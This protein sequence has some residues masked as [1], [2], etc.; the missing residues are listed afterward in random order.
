[1]VW[2]LKE[3]KTFRKQYPLNEIMINNSKWKYIDIRNNKKEDTIIFLH[4]T[5][6]SAEIFWLQL[7]YF[8]KDYRVIS[9]TISPIDD[10]FQ[11]ATQLLVII[12]QLGV[13][14]PI[15]LG[16]SYGG[17]IS[18]ILW[19]CDPTLIKTLVLSN[20][21]YS[22][23]KYYDRYNYLMKIKRF[24]PTFVLKNMVRK[25]L[26][27]IIHNET[28][29]YLL[30]QLN[31]SLDKTVLLA[32]LSGIVRKYS[33]QVVQMRNMLILETEND[34]LIPKSVQDNLKLTYSYAKVFTF[35]ESANH[36]PYLTRSHEYNKVLENYLK[37]N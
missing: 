14:S 28:R 13:N 9:F 33:I 35:P 1:M 34:P 6:G 16:T 22:T 5:T 20:S 21:F 7:L 31:Q 24:I 18:Q 27:L 17:Y 32:R 19:S 4:G 26:Q 23:E 10:P 30:T 11:V 3:L 37:G 36:F 12:K 2:T 8:Q 25:E 15:V 29:D